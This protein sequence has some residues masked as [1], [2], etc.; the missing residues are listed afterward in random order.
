MLASPG[1]LREV[2]VLTEIFR[3]PLALRP[4]RLLS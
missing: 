3:P 2:A 4:R 1:K